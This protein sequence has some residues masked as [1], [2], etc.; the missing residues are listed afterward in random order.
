M[1]DGN[2]SFFTKNISLVNTRRVQEIIIETAL[3]LPVTLLAL[4]GNILVLVA[5]YRNPRLQSTAHYFIATLALT[6]LL[7]ACISQPLT[8][9]ALFSGK[10]QAGAFGCQLHGF[11][12]SF[13]TYTSSYTMVLTAIN[14]YVKVIR[15]QQYPRYFG[16][17][18]VLAL[19]TFIW[20]TNV[21]V[22]LAP[23]IGGWARFEFVYVFA[24]CCLKFPKY[25]EAS[26]AG[27]EFTTFSLIPMIIISF[28]YYRVSKTIQQHN[29][30]ANASL[31]S[32]E[33]SSTHIAEIRVTNILF[34]LV[35]TFFACIFIGFIMVLICRVV[36]GSVLESVGFILTYLITLTTAVNPV[37]YTCTSK[38]FRKE[39]LLILSVQCKKLT[40]ERVTPLPVMV[41]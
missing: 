34:S 41:K 12:N 26:W 17:K 19:L 4:V 35:F 24:A 27:F 11:F 37:L 33:N 20:I 13:L 18:Q 15:P 28:C 22:T 21:V 30:N 39:F 36:A 31:R 40:T 2:S 7:S 8:L 10:W 29:Q 25:R 3:F 5:V 16:K 23:V 32:A 14:R 1:T 9:T 6:D 38:D